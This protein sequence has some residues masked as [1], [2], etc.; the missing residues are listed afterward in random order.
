MWTWNF[1][2]RAGG[3]RILAQP[4]PKPG[5]VFNGHEPFESLVNYQVFVV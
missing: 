2:T 5:D 1:E 4:R 3:N